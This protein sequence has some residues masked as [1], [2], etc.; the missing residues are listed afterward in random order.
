MALDAFWRGDKAE[1]EHLC[2]GEVLS[3]FSAAIDER[4]AAG[5]VLDNRLVRIEEA[6]IVGAAFA[7]P[8]ARVTVRFVADIAAV[9]RDAAGTV[10]AGSLNDA[11]E[12]RD[13]WTFRRDIGSA[14]PDWVLED[15]D[16]G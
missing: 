4:V 6:V 2:E 1:L 5:E 15:T 16:E 11:V 3:S 10:V 8:Y 7:A 12:V 13:V 9:T 14:H